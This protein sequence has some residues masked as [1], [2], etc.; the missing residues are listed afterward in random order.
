MHYALT[1]TYIELSVKN[2]MLKLGL[3]VDEAILYVT[4]T[5]D[6]LYHINQELNSFGTI[7]GLQVNMNKI[8]IYPVPFGYTDVGTT[9]RS[10]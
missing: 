2:K 6:S 3:F 4:K 10:L 1:S 9:K 5:L 7:T 8:E